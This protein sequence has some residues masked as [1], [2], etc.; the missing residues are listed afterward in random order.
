MSRLRLA[1]LLAT[2][3]TACATHTAP[4]QK[5]TPTER[6]VAIDRAKLRARLAER[7]KVN[8]E[9]FL[10]YREA[11]VY[12]INNQGAG[13]T[14][15]MWFDDWGH[16][17]AA[18]TLISYDWGVESTVNAGTK[19]RFMALANVKSGPLADWILTSGLTHHEIVAIQAPAIDIT[20]EID[21][22]PEIARLY[23]MYVDVERQ[24]RTL[25]DES[26]DEAT[27]A[28]MKHPELARQLLDGRVAGPG[29]FATPAG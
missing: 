29:P 18:A 15:H 16:L 13:T 10:A 2:S 7:R 22:S 1:L 8:V 27:D 17:C 26:L 9:H 20:P 11:R 12:P 28:L 6:A 5:P 19:D 23:T 4:V 24:L 3:L 21:R 14:K 25:S